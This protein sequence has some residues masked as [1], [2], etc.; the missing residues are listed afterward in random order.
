MG[1]IL[2]TATLALLLMGGGDDL[3]KKVKYPAFTSASEDTSKYIV[4]QGK[5]YR[6]RPPG[7]YCDPTL[8]GTPVKEEPQKTPPFGPLGFGIGLA[9]TVLTAIAM[10]KKHDKIIEK[11]QQQRGWDFFGVHRH[12]VVDYDVDRKEREF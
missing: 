8:Y 2:K 10:R 3:E 9:A 1:I 6:Q 12:P 7:A 4:I 5:T 11:Y